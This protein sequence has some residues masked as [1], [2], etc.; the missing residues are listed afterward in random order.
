MLV[1]RD[2]S[3]STCGLDGLSNE[4]GR[5]RVDDVLQRS[6]D[7]RQYDCVTSRDVAFAEIYMVDRRALAAGPTDPIRDRDRQVDL[8][9]VD[10]AE[11][12][13]EQCRV[14]G[15]DPRPAAHRRARMNSE[16]EASSW[17]RVD[18]PRSLDRAAGAGAARSCGGRGV[19]VQWPYTR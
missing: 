16:T 3:A 9:R 18:R 2:R 19:S 11:L 14:V 17:G 7:R 5:D 6:S 1:G 4:V 12:V 8:G 15:D 13:D 10:V